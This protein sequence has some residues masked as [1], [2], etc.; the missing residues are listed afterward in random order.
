MKAL[1]VVFFV[2]VAD[3]RVETYNYISAREDIVEEND[4]GGALELI[5][6]VGEYYKLNQA[7]YCSAG[8]HK[9]P[10]K[11]MEQALA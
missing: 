6:E 10:R 3:G 11:M 5:K 9:I 7:N 8:V 4:K 1:Y 2:R